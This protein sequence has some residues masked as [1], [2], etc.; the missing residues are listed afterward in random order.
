M[1][2]P[3]LKETSFKCD[4][5][6]ETD[7]LASHIG[8][9]YSKAT[10]HPEMLDELV[11]LCEMAYHANGSIRGKLAVTDE[12]I[13]KAVSIHDKYRDQVKKETRMFSLPIGCE[14]AGILNLCRSKSKNATRWAYK[15][16]KNEGTKVEK[17]VTDM[18]NVMSDIFFVMSVYANKMEGIETIE[19]V[20]KSYDVR[21]QL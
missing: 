19:F 15:I 16:Q 12:D 1:C 9:A 3:Y 20:S 8:Y 14:L 6:I 5:E 4:F 11:W 17:R 18:L 13:A 2:Y 7:S 21:F 10:K